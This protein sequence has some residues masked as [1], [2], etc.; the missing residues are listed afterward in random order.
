MPGWPWRA[1]PCCG[2]RPSSRV[3]EAAEVERREAAV[4]SSEPEEPR[5]GPATPAEERTAAAVA[6]A[7]APE[8]WADAAETLP[9][10]AASATAIRMPEA[11]E[12]GTFREAT[13]TIP[14]TAWD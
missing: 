5:A 1:I 6:L 3:A 7:A 13:R 9:A 2:L 8:G 14:S 4:A 12:A 10:A 11:A